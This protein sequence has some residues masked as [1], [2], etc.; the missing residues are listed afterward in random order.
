MT[1][2][3]SFTEHLINNNHDCKYIRHNNEIQH[4]CLKE[5]YMDALEQFELY[6]RKGRTKYIILKLIFNLTYKSGQ[7]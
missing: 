3:Y 1:P 4:F 6:T 7:R 5:K 2:K